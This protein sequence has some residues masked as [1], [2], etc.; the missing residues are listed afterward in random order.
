MK[1]TPSTLFLR[2]ILGAALLLLTLG[3]P[4]RAGNAPAPSDSK[5]T[6]IAECQMVTLPQ[7]LAWPL[8]PDLGDDEKIDAAWAKLQQM[9]EQGQATLVANL[10]VRGDT[11]QKM[12]AEEIREVRYPTE[13]TPPQ[14]PQEIR[15]EKNAAYK[16]LPI[17]GACP[18]AFETRNV[19]ATLELEPKVSDDGQWIALGIAVQHV[20]FLR[21]HKYDI[22]VVH[23]G[24]HQYIEQPFFSTLSDTFALHL[25]T[26]QRVLLGL[27]KIPED[28]ANMELFFLRVRTQPTTK[29]K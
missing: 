12:I 16:D 27:H 19:G 11:E 29:A 8:L 17:T 1:L 14:I 20:R 9:I 4:G 2:H 6:V 23:S 21:F 5:W 28:E 13:F 24:E 10:S 26:G 3:L 18:T 15:L 25:H 7:K 22:G